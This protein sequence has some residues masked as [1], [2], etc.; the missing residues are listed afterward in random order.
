MRLSQELKLPCG[1][2]LSNRLAKSAMSENMATQDHAPGDCF[3]NLYRRWAL[4]GIG[5]CI[6]GNV[7][8]DKNHLGE[9]NNVVLENNQHLDLFK[10]WS[11]STSGTQTSL[12]LQINHPG[13]QIPKF[14]SKD[15][16]AP[17]AIPLDPG[18]RTMFATPRALLEKEI[19]E[20]IHRFRQTAS[21]AK[22]AGFH[23]IQIHAAHGYLINQFLS[24]K[25]NQRQDN[26]GGSLENRMRF[27]LEVYNNVR[28]EVGATFPIGV[29]INSADFQKGGFSHEDAVL[30]CRTLSDVGIDLI[31]ISGGS[32]EKPVMMSGQNESTRSRE[33]YFLQY[34]GDIKKV[35]KCPLMLTG[36]FRSQSAMQQAIESGDVDLIGLARPLAIEPDLPRHLFSESNIVSRVYPISSGIKPLDRLFALDISW[37]TQQ[38]HRMGNGLEPNIHAS[39]WCSM[40]STV[41]AIGLHGVRRVRA[42]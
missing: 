34:A 28:A 32:Y 40:C 33:A 17:S 1:Y 19:F 36:G 2:V 9:P 5:L 26:W 38:L 25:H 14:L 15:L 10:R 37:Y 11:S 22:S 6:S 7:M 42:K 27:L 18:I 4:G 31:E 30:V 13:K 21:L 35:I 20:I 41:K 24:E 3:Y 39:T 23:G 16:V 8:I 29:K 12:W